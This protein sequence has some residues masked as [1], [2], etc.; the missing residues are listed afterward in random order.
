[1]ATATL[2]TGTIVS[3]SSSSPVCLP[4][5]PA[6]DILYEVVNGQIVESSPMGSYENDI[7]NLLAELLNET[8]RKDRLGR[9]FVEA[10][11]LID[12]D[13]NLKRRPDLAFVSS[14]RWPL[15]RRVPHE[16][17]WEMVPDLAVEVVS[18]SNGAEEIVEKV[19]EYFQTGS[20]LVWVVYPRARQVYVY[21]SPIQVRILPESADIDGGEVVPGF[22]LSLKRLFEDEPN[23]DPATAIGS[24][25]ASSSPELPNSL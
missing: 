14:A 1:M 18:K 3:T 6:G 8:A 16:E 2:P 7:A 13:Q 22:R 5:E 11:F 19:G 9:A 21:T 12:V 23:A 20:R 24:A 10:L 25:G 17:A 4:L 15:G